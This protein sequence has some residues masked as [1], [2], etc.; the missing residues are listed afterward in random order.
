MADWITLEKKQYLT[1]E[2]MSAFANNIN[3]IRDY[4]LSFGLNVGE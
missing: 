4:L 1:V 2:D 3:Y